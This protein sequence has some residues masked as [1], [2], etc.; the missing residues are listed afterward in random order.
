MD[1][2]VREIAKLEN[3]GDLYVYRVI[4]YDKGIGKNLWYQVYLC[5]VCGKIIG[6]YSEDTS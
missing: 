6:L 3:D 5:P 1:V 2:E 4:V